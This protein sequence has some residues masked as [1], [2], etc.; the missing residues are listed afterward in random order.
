MRVCT[1]EC[2]YH[3]LLGEPAAAASILRT[4]LSPLS[5]LPDRARWRAI[6]AVR[7]GVCHR[8]SA[9]DVGC[10]IVIGRG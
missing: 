7:P 3:Y 5:A 8:R 6:E 1:T 9:S 10:A 2:L 4:G